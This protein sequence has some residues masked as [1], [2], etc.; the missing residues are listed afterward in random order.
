ME[1]PVAAG[2]QHQPNIA[3]TAARISLEAL[4]AQPLFAKLPD[5]TLAKLQLHVR[6]ARFEKGSVILRAG[7][8]N[9]EAHYLTDGLVEVR[10]P[11]GR[12][13]AAVKPS[14]ER[15]ADQRWLAR[16]S[17]MLGMPRRKP[18]A[19]ASPSASDKTVVLSDMP[20]DLSPGGRAV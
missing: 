11:E 3:G 13:T 7:V 17:G 6:E 18:A 19:T 5:S 4:R 1:P 20:V 16:L 12:S 15:A 10:F 2:H 9:T 14:I 8:Y